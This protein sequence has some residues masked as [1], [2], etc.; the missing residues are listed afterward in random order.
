MAYSYYLKAVAAARSGNNSE[1]ISNLKTA[2]EK[3]N[4]LKAYAKDDAEFIKLRAD[5]GFTALIN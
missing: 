1:V 5:S 4:A 2:V 3:D